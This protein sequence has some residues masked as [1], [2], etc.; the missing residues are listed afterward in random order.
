MQIFG[1]RASSRV[2]GLVT[3]V[4]LGAFL[5]AGTPGFAAP[6]EGPTPAVTATKPAAAAPGTA[7]P[8]PTTTQGKLTSEGYYLQGEGN[9]SIIAQSAASDSPGT[10][11]RAFGFSAKGG[12]RWG[13]KAVFVTLEGSFWRSPLV[14]GGSE[15]VMATNIG[16]GGEILSAG[17]ILRTSLAF[18]PSILT[19]PPKVDEA[20]KVGIFFDLRPLGCRFGLSQALVLGVDPLSFNVTVPVLSGI[21]L[22]EIEYRT[23]VYVEHAF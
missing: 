19:I 20:G 2:C 17:G 11:F 1:K 16:V 13:N 21:P 8:E 9:V 7:P 22:I 10:F 18:G 15:L 5:L 14:E 23:S 3:Y 6:Q 12:H 4:T